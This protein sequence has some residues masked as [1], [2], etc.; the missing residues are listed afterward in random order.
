M[1]L[2]LSS[3]FVFLFLFVFPPFFVVQIVL[4][5]NAVDSE[6]EMECNLSHEVSEYVVVVHQD[7]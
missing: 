1:F 2:F 4:C 6:E 5:A 3:F 7:R